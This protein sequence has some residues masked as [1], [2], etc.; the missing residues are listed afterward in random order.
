[1]HLHTYKEAVF[2]VLSCQESVDDVTSAL[3]LPQK[4]FKHF[5]HTHGYSKL[6]DMPIVLFDLNGTLCHRT[7]RNRKITLRPNILELKKLKKTYRIGVYTSCTRYNALVVCDAI[8]DVCGHIFDRHLIF[9][10]EHTVPFTPEEQAELGFAP[11]KTK[12]SLARI[13]APEYRNRTV[14]IDDELARIE[15]KEMAIQIP[16]W[17]S[18]INGCDTTL[19]NLVTHLLGNVQVHSVRRALFTS[20][21]SH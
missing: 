6:L 14:I 15:E 17:Y 11:Y 18:D 8:E 1:M 2:R 21:A 7:D 5:L 12:K 16:P 3:N 9:T 19:S 4:Q 10:R 13:I 20:E